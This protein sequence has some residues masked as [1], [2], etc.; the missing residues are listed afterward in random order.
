MGT[1]KIWIAHQSK[2][3]MS[4]T[5]KIHDC[6]LSGSSPALQNFAELDFFLIL[7][8]LLLSFDIK[9]FALKQWLVSSDLFPRNKRGRDLYSDSGRMKASL[10]RLPAHAVN[11]VLLFTYLFHNV[12]AKTSVCLLTSWNEV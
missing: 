12:I 8:L 5:L 4:F 7:F 1:F 9:L 3:H 6:M 10:L 11:N 2:K